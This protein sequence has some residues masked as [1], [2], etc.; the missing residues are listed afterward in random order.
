MAAPEHPQASPAAPAAPS[1]QLPEFEPETVFYWTSGADGR[2]RISRCRGCAR[3]I[4]PPLPS[5]PRCGGEVAPEPVSGTGR[6]KSFTVN[7]QQWLPGMQVPFVFAAVELAEQA[8]LYV[9][10]NIVGCPV[11]R[12]AIGMPVKVVFE[13]IEDVHLP[14]F[15]PA[16]AADAR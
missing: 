1:R 10:T 9:L 6:V 7:V 8:E 13:R 2:L 15:A 12:V 14:L 5:C 3:F 11:D 16:E 4:H